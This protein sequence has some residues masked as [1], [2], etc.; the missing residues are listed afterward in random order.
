M[1]HITEFN[2]DLI[3]HGKLKLDPSR[4][5]KIITTYHDS[6]NPA[7]AAGLLDEPGNVLENVC[8]NSMKCLKTHSRANILLRWRSRLGQRRKPGN[9]DE[10][11][12][13]E[14]KCPPA[15]SRLARSQSTHLY[16]RHRQ[17]DPLGPMPLLGARGDGRRHP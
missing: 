6:C 11:R 9:E 5:K 1:V 10:G 3:K 13:P 8:E 16:V 17:S 7:R 15:R 12:L 4:N 2:G 14:R